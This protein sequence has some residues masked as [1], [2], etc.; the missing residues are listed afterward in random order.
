MQDYLR[1][2]V[3]RIGE[4]GRPLSRNRH[5]HT[6]ATPLGKKA[7]KLSRQLRSLARDILAQDAEGGAIGVER[8]ADAE[9][10]VR[11]LLHL[12]RLKAKRTAFLSQGEWELLLQE[13]GVEE[14]LARRGSASP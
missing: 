6:F 14:A 9:G 1:R 3:V 12:V 4:T 8:Q 7:L 10:R 11:V 13:P 5:F 2:L